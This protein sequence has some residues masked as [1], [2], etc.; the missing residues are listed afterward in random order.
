MERFCISSAVILEPSAETVAGIIRKTRPDLTL[1]VGLDAPVPASPFAVAAF[2]PDANINRF[3]KAVWVH[4]NGA[5][6]DKLLRVMEFTPPRMSRTVGKMGAQMAEYV[7]AYVLARAQKISLRQLA[8]ER[9]EWATK[10]L[11]P[12]FLKGR[13]ALVCGTGP[14]GQEIAR[15]L[16]AFGIRCDGV[17]RQGRLISPFQDVVTLDRLQDIDPAQIDIIVLALPNAPG[18][19]DMINADILQQFNGAQLINVGRGEVLKLDDL[20]HALDQNFIAEAVLDVLPEEPLPPMSPLWRQKGLV[21][22]PHVSGVTRPEDAAEAFLTTLD[23]FER[24]QMAPH[25][26][27]PTQGY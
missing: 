20:C 26:V 17:S 24:G 5:G 25:R 8:A 23:A 2:N 19:R 12:V 11:L 21:I 16:N 18:T 15:R 14:I 10:E 4:C 22:T 9:Q 7:L 1:H 13:R 27:E 3:H 6:V